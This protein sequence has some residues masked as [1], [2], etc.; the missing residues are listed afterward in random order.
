MMGT[1]NC[2]NAMRYHMHC[3]ERQQEGKF[4]LSFLAAHGLS[5]SVGMLCCE[6]VCEQW[7]SSCAPALLH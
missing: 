3:T 2:I 7:R 1:A 6:T 4:Y 5:G